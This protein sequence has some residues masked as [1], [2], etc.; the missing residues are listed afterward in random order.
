ME[1]SQKLKNLTEQYIELEDNGA[2]QF[3]GISR[4]I[5]TYKVKWS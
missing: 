4:P 1:N 3:K 2:H 5:N